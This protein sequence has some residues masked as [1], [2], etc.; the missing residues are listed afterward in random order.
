MK[1]P[2]F[3]IADV[4]DRFDTYI[5][6]YIERPG[7]PVVYFMNGEVIPS[8]WSEKQMDNCPSTHPK[9]DWYVEVT[10]EEIVLRCG[11]IPEPGNFK[12]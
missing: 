12:A 11:F 4:V 8:S 9:N 10:E 1:Y 3:F 6:H 7:G 2:R 5:C